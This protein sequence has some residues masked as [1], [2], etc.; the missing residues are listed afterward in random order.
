MRILD[1]LRRA[2][3]GG[4]NDRDLERCFARVFSSPA[5]ERVLDNLAKA[6][7]APRVGAEAGNEALQRVE[8]MRHLLNHILNMIERGKSDHG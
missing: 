6:A 7:Y 2:R 8:G 5:G 1:L 4:P 3:R